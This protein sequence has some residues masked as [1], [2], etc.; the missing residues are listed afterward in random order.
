MVQKT[1]IEVLQ[2]YWG[3]QAF[4]PLQEEIIS[5]VLAGQ[6]TLA[7]LPTGGGKSICFQIPGLIAPGLTIVVSP[8]ISLMKDQVQRLN[9][10]GIAATAV[11][12]DL[13]SFELD[14]KLQGAMDGV[15][16]FLYLS[17]ERIK[18]ELFRLRL[19]KMPL[20]LLAIDEAHC[21]SQWGHDFRPAYRDIAEI[22]DIHP[23]VAIIALTASATPV[24]Q[25]DIT[26]QLGLKNVQRF[27]KSF[28]RPNLR[29]FVLEETRVTERVVEIATK[30]QGTGIVYARTRKATEVLSDLLTKS[31]IAASPY[32]GGL[33]S[34]QRHHTQEEWQAGGV[35]V[36]VATNAFGMG[37]D[38]PDV[39][40]VLHFHLP[41]DLESYYQEAG[42]GGRDGLTALAIAFFN[43]AELTTLERWV[44]Q[45]YPSWKQVSHTYQLLCNEYQITREA[46]SLD[47]KL[48]DIGSLATKTDSKPMSLYRTLQILHK[49]GLI[50]LSDDRDDYAYLMVHMAPEDM[51]AYKQRNPSLAKFLDFM[52]RTL[53][54]EIFGREAR[55]LPYQWQ[56]KLSIQPSEWDQLIAR[57][58]NQKVISYK[59]PRSQPTIRFLQARH[60]LMREQLNWDKYLGLKQESQKKLAAMLG[61]AQ[62]QNT[63]RSKIIQEY[64]GEKN[65]LICGVCDVCIGRYKSKVNHGEYSELEASIEHSLRKSPQT[66]RDLIRYGK[67]GTPAQ[68]EKVIRYLMDKRRILLTDEGLLSLPE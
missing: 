48:L 33:T 9:K 43:P 34:S 68:R 45:Q 1:P 6:D 5:S 10:M 37:I 59:A 39:R 62:Q 46:P 20:S 21:I 24:V 22:R 16:R 67:V 40:F 14:Q 42:R 66:Y 51:Y 65:V 11:T 44:A 50:I 38:K 13:N 55:F 15:Y 4:R 8:L 3:H 19:P 28:A 17:P 56:E 53:G 64:F 30:V 49:E 63:C 57:L 41:T 60:T 7:L 54:G 58:T 18:S 29:Y 61:Y 35:R 32:H 25:E 23:S 12:S 47:P 52:L 26:S 2:Q 31:G 27:D 36:V